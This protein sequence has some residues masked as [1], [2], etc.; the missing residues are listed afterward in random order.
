MAS[1]HS[2][3][4]YLP[5]MNVTGPASARLRIALP[6]PVGDHTLRIHSYGVREWMPPGVLDRPHGQEFALLMAFNHAV[7]IG[8]EDRIIAVPPASFIAWQ[9]WAPHRYGHPH[10]IWNHSWINLEGAALAGF[11][12][13]S[14][15][16]L[17]TPLIGVPPRMLE[18]CILAVHDEL[19][20][21]MATDSS[22]VRNHIHTLLR[23]VARSVQGAAAGHVA[24]PLLAVRSHLE[25]RYAEPITLRG[26][27]RLAGW[28]VAHLSERFRRAFGAAPIDY[29]IRIR[30]AQAHLL[31]RERGLSVAAT[32]AAVGYAEYHHFTK[33]FRKR[34]GYPPSAVRQGAALAGEKGR[35]RE[36]PIR[37]Q[38]HMHARGRLRVR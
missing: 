21:G 1:N 6:D 29:L 25:T 17:D 8:V 19:R 20:H 31:L 30:L 11:L 9:P 12:A 34:Y 33:L 18:R 22:I 32:A 13:G 36:P 38:H 7:E 5:V 26:L 15:I 27:A 16:P 23:Q 28:S 3:M 10:T 4:S 2:D 35:Q 24:P 14:G 37:S